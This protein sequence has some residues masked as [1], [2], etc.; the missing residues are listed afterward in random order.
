MH[1]T[2]VHAEWARAT[3]FKVW[4]RQAPQRL[5][6]AWKTEHAHRLSEFGAAA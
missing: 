3:L 1:P 5:L 6:A 4:C 2:A